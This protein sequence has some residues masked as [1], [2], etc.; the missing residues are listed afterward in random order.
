[1][2]LLCL[3]IRVFAHPCQILSFLGAI[4][5]GLEFAGYGG[6]HGY[7][8]YAIG[9]VAPAVAWPTVM[10]PVEYALI[11]QFAAFTLL[12]YVDT[13]AT[14]RGW[15]PPWYAI[16]RFTLTF[17]VGASIVLTLIGRGEIAD[18]GQNISGPVK[19][20]TDTRETQEEAIAEEEEIIRA[21]QA[22]KEAKFEDDQGKK[23]KA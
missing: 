4:H 2:R 13:R 14:A 6:H 5:W 1:M 16:Y 23:S 8:R 15:T 10:M 12:Y 7:K 19:R 17:I 11:S 3:T 18:R 22:G 9:V 20:Y 21:Q